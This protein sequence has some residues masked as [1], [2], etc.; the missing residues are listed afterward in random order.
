MEKLGAIMLKLR[1][2]HETLIPLLFIMVLKVLVG[3]KRQEKDI[4]EIQLGTKLK[5]FLFI[6]DIILYIRKSIILP[7]N[8]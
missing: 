2:R 8:F 5:L 3:G 7:E 4:K 6:N 1:M